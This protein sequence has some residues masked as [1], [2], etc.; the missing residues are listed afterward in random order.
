VTAR[1][2]LE[3]LADGRLCRATPLREVD[4]C[5]FH[6]PGHAEEVAEARRL[7][8]HRR[9]RERTV[10][11]A[12]DLAGLGDVQAIQR[13]LE[14]AAF[15]TLALPASLD[16]SRVLIAIAAASLRLVETRDLAD[17]VARL[18]AA[19]RAGGRLPTEPPT[20]DDP[21]GEEPEA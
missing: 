4:R 11:A 21:L 8:G 9:S 15:D 16:R 18:E 20:S 14:I 19:N 13:L 1:R 3:I 5:V 12:F 6:D 2:C 7:G 10:A 17:R